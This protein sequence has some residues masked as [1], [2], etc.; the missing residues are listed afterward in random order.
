[1]NTL[2][3]R[4]FVRI[5]IP[6]IKFHFSLFAQQQMAWGSLLLFSSVHFDLWADLILSLSI[7][8]YAICMVDTFDVLMDI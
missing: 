8:H 3:N 7:L 2:Q 1:M 5:K 4:F 6:S